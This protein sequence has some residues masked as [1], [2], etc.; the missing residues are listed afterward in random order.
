MKHPYRCLLLTLPLLLLAFLA[1]S[2]SIN[3]DCSNAQILCAKNPLVINELTGHGSLREA[4]MESC[5]QNNFE[6]TNSIWLK[7]RVAEAGSLSFTILP[8]NESDDIDFVLYRI[9]SFENCTIKEPIRCM[10]AG[11]SM[12]LENEPLSGCTGATGLRPSASS[13][14]RPAGCTKD[15]DNFLRPIEMQANEHYALWINNYRSSGGVMVEWSGTGTFHSIPELC[16][17]ASGTAANQT[18]Q[19][20]NGIQFSEVFP[21][22]ATQTISI[23]ATSTDEQSGQL[24]LIGTDGQIA[25][26]LPFALVAGTNTINLSIENLRAGVHFIKLRTKGETHLLRFIKH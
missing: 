16:A 5:F 25:S 8:L 12:G 4:S 7:W 14:S 23:N 1:S 9:K 24:Q 6:E 2:Q 20:G 11:P 26:E 3:A 15:G 22:P 13:D 19:S 10:A 17:P 21:N 18:L